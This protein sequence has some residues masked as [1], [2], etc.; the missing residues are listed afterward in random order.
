MRQLSSGLREFIRLLSTKNVKDV[1][2]G[3]WA[4]AFHGQPR[5]TGD[6]GIFVS[7]DS[8]NAAKLTDVLGEFGFGGVGIEREDFCK[9]RW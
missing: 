5:Y 9:K 3:A 2:A 1:I 8:D 7:C 6:L 4:L